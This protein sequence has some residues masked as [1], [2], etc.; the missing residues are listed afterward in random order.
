MFEFSKLRLNPFPQPPVCRVAISRYS[1]NPLRAVVLIW[2]QAT[3]SL[4]LSI[5]LNTQVTRGSE[6]THSPAEELP[7]HCCLKSASAHHTSPQ[8]KGLGVPKAVGTR[9]MT[10]L[11]FHAYPAVKL[12]SDALEGCIMLLWWLK[13]YWYMPNKRQVENRL[14]LKGSLSQ[15]CLTLRMDFFGGFFGMQSLRSRQ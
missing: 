13:P 3:L 8:L 14:A 1:F 5:I 12:S 15:G 7:G 4:F 11:V 10:F 2:E 6:S 9:L